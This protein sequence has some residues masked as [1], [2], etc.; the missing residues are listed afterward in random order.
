[1]DCRDNRVP[2]LC[3]Q[4]TPRKRAKVCTKFL[5]IPSYLLF[6]TCTLNDCSVLV[7]VQGLWACDST[8]QEYGFEKS[9]SF[10]VFQ[11]DKSVF[12][13]FQSLSIQ[14]WKL[15]TFE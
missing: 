4:T 2:L 6:E 14:V 12:D 10:D 15:I 8:R 11:S 13:M 1:M 3:S 5:K 7:E 9:D